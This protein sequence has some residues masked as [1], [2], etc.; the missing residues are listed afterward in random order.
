L[1]KADKPPEESPTA[2]QQDSS[3]LNIDPELQSTENDL[4]IQDTTEVPTTTTEY[5]HLTSLQSNI[6]PELLDAH[7]SRKVSWN[8][9][10]QFMEFDNGSGSST[11]HGDAQ[12]TFDRMDPLAGL[13]DIT[14]DPFLSNAEWYGPL[15]Q[16]ISPDQSVDMA[17]P[18]WHPQDYF[19]FND[20]VVELLRHDRSEGS[21][22]H[23]DNLP[24]ILERPQEKSVAEFAPEDLRASLLED[25]QKYIPAEELRSLELPRTRFLQ[26]FLR[27]YIKSFHCHLP[28]LHITQILGCDT[29]SPLRLAICC[30]GAL[31]LMDRKNATLFKDLGTKALRTVSIHLHV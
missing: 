1:N 24:V 7:D 29:P 31:Y 26:K 10:A 21:I 19:P 4:V 11:Q 6:D 25:L 12:K 2:S 16:Q 27:S 28:I 8:M 22:K 5:T 3:E 17:H 9:E 23:V 18:S 15:T 13:F 20:Q 30:I 14:Q